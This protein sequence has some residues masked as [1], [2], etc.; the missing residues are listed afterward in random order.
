[1]SQ[2]RRLIALSIFVAAVPFAFTLIRAAR[3]GNDLRY[4]WV[5]LA[6]LLGALA[7]VAV[8]RASVCT[9]AEF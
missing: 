4:F 2:S 3:T 7:T 6:S 9:P 1:M 5:A 8:G